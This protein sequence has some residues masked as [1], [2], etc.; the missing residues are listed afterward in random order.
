M[1][2]VSHTTMKISTN[3]AHNH[4][5]TKP[6]KEDNAGQPKVLKF[7]NLSVVRLEQDHC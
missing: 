1:T 5:N 7:L 2:A 4:G 3:L 6:S